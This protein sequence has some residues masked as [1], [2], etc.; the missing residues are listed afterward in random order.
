MTPEEHRRYAA[1]CYALGWTRGI[2]DDFIRD[3]EPDLDRA[4]EVLDASATS[5]IARTLGITEADLNP[6]WHIYLSE[7]ERWRLSGR[8]DRN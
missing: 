7:Q 2:I 5:E 1:V 4:K 8:G 3:Q 6:D